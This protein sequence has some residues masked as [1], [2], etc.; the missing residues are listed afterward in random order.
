MYE[1]YYLLFIMHYLYFIATSFLLYLMTVA[2]G[3]QQET[4]GITLNIF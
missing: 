3:Q 1:I 2:Q 4:D